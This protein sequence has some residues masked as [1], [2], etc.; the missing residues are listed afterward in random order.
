MGCSQ[1]TLEKIKKALTLYATGGSLKDCCLEV[2]TNRVVIYEARKQYPIIDAAYQVA[3]ELRADLLADEV[4]EISDTETNPHKARIRCEVRLKVAGFFNRK[5]YGEHVD[6]TVEGRVDMGLALMEAKQRL[7]KHLGEIQEIAD[8]EVID[9]TA[10]IEAGP[11]DNESVDD[12][13]D[14]A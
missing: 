10:Q 5:V 13:F 4:V 1:E 9:S 3:R 7:L 14:G 2:G 6:M 12:P 11:T 8:G